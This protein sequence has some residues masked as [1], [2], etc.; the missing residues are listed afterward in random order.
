MRAARWLIM[1]LLAMGPACGGEPAPALARPSFSVHEVG[2]VPAA[3]LGRLRVP[4][5]ADREAFVASADGER[6]EGGRLVLTSGRDSGPLEL[7]VRRPIPPGPWSAVEVHGSLA[8]EG[9]LSVA[10]LEGGVEVV[11][12]VP[13]PLSGDGSALI[14]RLEL[15]GFAPTDASLD[16]ARLTLS[17]GNRVLGFEALEFVPA[18]DLSSLPDARTGP[19]PTLIG[20]A[21]RP[22]VGLL[23]GQELRAAVRPEPGTTLTFAFGLPAG[24]VRQGE[25]RSPED[26]LEVRLMAGGEVVDQRRFALR[27]GPLE[28]RAW[29]DVDWALGRFAGR[30]LTVVLSLRPG[31]SSRLSACAVTPLQFSRPARDAPTV[32]L[33]TSDTHRADHLGAAPDGVDVLTPVLDGLAARGVLF[34]DC[35]STTNVTGPS[36]QALLTGLHPRDLGPVLNGVPLPDVVP[37]LA[38]AFAREGYATLAVVSARHLGHRGSGLA[39]GFDLIDRPAGSQREAGPSVGLLLERLGRWEGRPVF[40]WLHLFDAHTPYDPPDALRHAYYPP[41]RDPF[42]SDHGHPGPIA[43]SGM[44][45][46]R[47]MSFARSQYAAEVTGLDAALG[48]LLDQPRVRRGVTA[49]VADH[50]EGLG[51][52]R[53]HFG[54]AE[55]YPETVQ[56]PCLLAWPDA[57]AGSRVDVGVT[58]LDLGRTLLDLAGLEGVP[59]PGTDLRAADGRAPRFALSNG[60]HSASV[61]EGRWYLVLHLDDH[62]GALVSRGYVRHE[63]ELFDLSSDP[64]ADRDVAGEQPDQARRLRALLVDWLGRAAPLGGLVAPDEEMQALLSE[65]G[66][67]GGDLEAGLW[68]ADGCARCRLYEDDR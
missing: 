58:S 22:A 14:S 9:R 16:A 30:A 5:A 31:D 67:V 55:L 66:Y 57:P 63:V 27:F 62:H 33:I 64:D 20:R 41:D 1:A 47:D 60:R 15:L 49:V 25:A 51:E 19:E 40:A 2:A 13:R 42:A 11:R 10:L 4:V 29:V 21:W 18:F 36:H 7:T 43:P 8:G 44:E 46:L 37:T 68:E 50:G 65:L 6:L 3:D 34:S 48:P 26:E 23:P 32:L 52:H 53:V 38:E 24:L 28:T 45:G 35:L 54:H 61:R 56:V 12:S 59:F 39:R 17:G